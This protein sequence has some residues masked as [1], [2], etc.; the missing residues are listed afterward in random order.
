M[1]E[2]VKQRKREHFQQIK[3]RKN[4]QIFNFTNLILD[5]VAHEI[6]IWSPF[7]LYKTKFPHA[8]NFLTEMF[9]YSGALWDSSKFVLNKQL[10]KQ[11]LCSVRMN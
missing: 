4:M 6:H 3:S 11:N 9:C 8:W 7:L 1:D 5:N 10:G 2:L